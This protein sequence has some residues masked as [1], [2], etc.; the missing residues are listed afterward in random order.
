LVRIT[1][2]ALRATVYEPDRL[3]CNLCGEVFAAPVPSAGEKKYDESAASTVALFK[4][5]TGSPSFGSQHAMGSPLPATTQWHLV[6]QAADELAPV[7]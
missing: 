3:R 1:G 7:H 5:G 4:Y 6:K 2:T